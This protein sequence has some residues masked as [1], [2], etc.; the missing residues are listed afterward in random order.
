MKI[1]KRLVLNIVYYSFVLNKSIIYSTNRNESREFFCIYRKYF[2]SKEHIERCYN[3]SEKVLIDVCIN[4]LY[5]SVTTYDRIT[6]EQIE[7]LNLYKKDEKKFLV[8][9]C[10]EKNSKVNRTM[11]CVNPNP[12]TDFRKN[13]AACCEETKQDDFKQILRT[14]VYILS[15]CLSFVIIA[16]VSMIL[17]EKFPLFLVHMIVGRQRNIV[18][19]S[20]QEFRTVSVEG[21]SNQLQIFPSNPL[22]QSLPLPVIRLPMSNSRPSSRLDD[23]PSYDDSLEPSP[24]LVLAKSSSDMS[25][26]FSRSR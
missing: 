13:D 21:S 9:R 25:A 17:V 8:K 24:K 15:G 7:R 22:N 20:G 18:H 5:S 2:Y 11:C 14:G 19:R 16:L 10:P 4:H 6:E 12:I 23:P 26:K 1:L 3:H